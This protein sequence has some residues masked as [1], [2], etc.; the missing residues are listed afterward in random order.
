MIHS[1]E[2]LTESL[3]SVLRPDTFR[4]GGPSMR[5]RCVLIPDPFLSRHDSVESW[6]ILAPKAEA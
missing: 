4:N 2:G 3:L 1:L 5:T 6:R